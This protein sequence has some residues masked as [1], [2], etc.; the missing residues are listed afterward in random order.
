M[1][2]SIFILQVRICFFEATGE[3][4]IFVDFAK[5]VEYLRVIEDSVSEKSKY[6]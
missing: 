6:S 4:I 3:I 5:C 2:R 1:E